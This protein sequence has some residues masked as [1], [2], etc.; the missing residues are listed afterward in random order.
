[1]NNIIISETEEG[2]LS[3]MDK[4]SIM[5]LSLDEEVASMVLQLMEER[6]IQRLTTHASRMRGLSM[7]QINCVYKEFLQSLSQSSPLL[8][9]QARDQLKN[10]LKNIL[11]PERYDK[12][13]EFLETGNELSEGFES[14][15]WIDSDT[16]A[17]FLRNEHPQTIA[18]V[19]SH[20]DVEKAAEIL[21]LIPQKLQADIITRIANLDK[22]NPDLVRDVQEIII[23]EIMA[24][25]TNKSRHAGGSHAVAEIL[26]N[27]DSQSEK[28]VFSQMEEIDAEMVNVIR[29]LMF[30]FEDLL[31]IDDRGMQM[32]MKEIT[33]DVLTMSL[34]S[35]P[36][37]LSEKILRNISARAA[38]MIRDDLQTMGPTKLA[39]VEKAQHEIV[40]ICRRLEAE[41]KIM[42]AGKG[43]GEVF[44]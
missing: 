8:I 13:V 24:S 37:E 17:A 40:K 42:L 19:L 10:V 14:I 20:I 25:G 4:A 38:D 35:A 9:R 27:F 34:K 29:D 18:M 15:K 39:D 6:E 11:P 5:L 22:I 7:E 43:G 28:Y 41:G 31:K 16:I 33:N 2:E 23:T 12:F 21:L 1:M 26:N 32:I 44:V 30:T 3:G 36:E